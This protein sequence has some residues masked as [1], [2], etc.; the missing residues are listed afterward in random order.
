[1]PKE[2]S[3]FDELDEAPGKVGGRKVDWADI[4]RKIN[5]TGLSYTA[6]EV[7]ENSQL[8]NHVVTLFRTKNALDSLARQMKKRGPLLRRRTDGRTFWYGPLKDPEG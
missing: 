6:R 7:W 3:E 5:E 4:A 2:I 8:V 1:M